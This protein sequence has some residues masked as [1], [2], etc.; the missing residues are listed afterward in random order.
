[1]PPAAGVPQ[2]R[3][4]TA[5]EIDVA[6]G[7]AG[8]GD[9]LMSEADARTKGRQRTKPWHGRVLCALCCTLALSLG[10]WQRPALAAEAPEAAPTEAQAPDQQVGDQ[11]P[12]EGLGQ[13]VSP[14]E[15]SDPEVGD[16]TQDAGEELGEELPA[17]VESPVIPDDP[18]AVQAAPAAEPAAA[19]AG[20]AAAPDEAPDLSLPAQAEASGGGQGAGDGADDAS[21]V[22]VGALALET[23]LGY[24]VVVDV[25]SG[26]TADRANAQL[27]RSNDT[28]AQRWVLEG[29]GD[30]YYV[31]NV[32]SGKVLDVA[33]GTAIAGTN[34]QLY[35]KNGSLAQLWMPERLA[36]GAWVLRSLL[37]NGL[38]LDVAGGTRSNGTNLQVWRAN[39][40]SAQ[41][42]WLREDGAGAQPGERVLADGAY[43]LV[44]GLS[45]SRVIDVAGGSAASGANAQLYASNGTNAQRFWASYDGGYYRFQCTASG[46]ALE[47]CAGSP[48]A[49]T[50]VRLASP[51]RSTAQQW[52]LVDAGSGRYTLVNR[53]GGL[54]LDVAGGASASGTNVR[55]YYGN[56]SAAQSWRLVAVA[57]VSDGIYT[58]T[59]ASTGKVLDVS[60]GSVASGAR[61][62]RHGSN[63]TVAQRF[64]IRGIGSGAVELRG[65]S[66]GLWMGASGDAVVQQG[67]S[68]S[69]TFGWNGSGLVLERGGS[70]LGFGSDGKARLGTRGAAATLRPSTTTLMGSGYYALGSL[71]G[72][73]LFAEGSGRTEA[74]VS[75]R[76]SSSS[77]SQLWYVSALGKDRYVITNVRSGLVA[78]GRGTNVCH[79]RWAAKDAQRWD[80]RWDDARGCIVFVN[81]ASGTAMGVAGGSSAS[82]ANVALFAQASSQAQGWRPIT[83]A[84]PPLTALQ[85]RAISSA[86]RTPSPGA[87]LCAAWITNLF[88]N[89]GLGTWYGNA[90]D[91]YDRYCV[92]SYEPALRPGMIV[93]VSSHGHTWAG[94]IWGHVGIYIG[95]GKIMDNIGSIRTTSLSSWLSYYGNRVPPRWG[96]L[97][98]KALTA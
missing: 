44:S 85:Q 1:M 68:A 9:D 36:S 59:D 34:V 78:E 35:R 29:R 37:G 38:V 42:F 63:G 12:D 60:G 33:G 7:A 66:S 16:Q 20:E 91:M 88:A 75:A 73:W 19:G 6:R 49:T 71:C 93:A 54:V 46:L 96:W 8:Q 32:K 47:V 89:A 65:V 62:Q 69:W 27:Y 97:G 13:G 17:P 31:V 22:P 15:A 14:D 10:A 55:G 11:Q 3:A 86:K 5:G 43:S 51:N 50:N 53:A 95:D 74:N 76:A 56:G 48:V 82:G 79:A 18:D 30:A 41:S 26:S 21:R 40:S 84:E 70:S 83:K 28:A 57:P 87:G 23:A 98:N 77:Q 58:V 61:L 81:V 2:G 92:D 25:A 80:A 39:G 4:P 64:R 52:A 24:G 90:C 67:S 45:S 94:S 72:T